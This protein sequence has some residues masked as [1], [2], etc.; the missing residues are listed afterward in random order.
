M[1]QDTSPVPDYLSLLRL[2]GRCAVV[3]GG[4]NGIGRQTVHALA[5]AGAKVAVVDVESEKAEFV[6]REVDGVPLSGDIIKRSDVERIFAEARDR[7][8]K[9]D[10]VVDIVGFAYRGP[11]LECDDQIWKAQFDVVLNHAFLAMQIGGRAVADA[12]GG[13]L[14]FV[15]SISGIANL[16][17]Q[18]A[19][20]SAKAALRH[21]VSG[22]G[23]ELAPQKVRV[24]AVAP[25]FVR[26]PR[27]E[28]VLSEATWDTLGRDVIP[29]GR[30]ARPS[31]IAAPILFLLSELSSHVTG[32]TLLADGG[33][34]GRIPLPEFK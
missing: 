8:G 13:G 5:Q 27:L 2:D 17:D 16:P 4:G 23:K 22:M 18:I 24:N 10:A 9:V 12:G 15:A 28:G 3:L 20:G 32:H 14:V 21:L 25:G 31:E 7:M 11:L 26:T 19:Y 6:A 34:L 29:I 30:A 33:M 1:T